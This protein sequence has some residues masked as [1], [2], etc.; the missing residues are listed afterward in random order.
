MRG[1]KRSGMATR[2][3]WGPTH[4][5]EWE[6]PSTCWAVPWQAPVV[7]AACA[8]QG[9]PAPGSALQPRGTSRLTVAG[10]RT[11]QIKLGMV[12]LPRS[13]LAPS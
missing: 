4:P 12:V 9:D 11:L 6:P 3:G 5:T 8:Q 13:H 10:A 1:R 7:H 2:E